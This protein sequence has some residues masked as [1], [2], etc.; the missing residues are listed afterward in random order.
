MT[1]T[2]LQILGILGCCC[3]LVTVILTL[4]P[5]ASTQGKILSDSELS[6]TFGGTCGKVCTE[7]Y[8]C[9]PTPNP[10]QESGSYWYKWKEVGMLTIGS[11]S[12][13][14]TND[15]RRICSRQYKYTT[16]NRCQND[17][18]PISTD[19]VLCEWGCDGG[20]TG[21]P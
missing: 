16:E 4:G 11:T 9:V 10:C 2:K 7:Y 21:C 14:Y 18:N 17:T 15:K 1:N 8:V 6:A 3:A 12:G 19:N 13:T 20:T 5:I